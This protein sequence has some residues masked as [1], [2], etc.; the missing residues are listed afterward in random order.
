MSSSTENDIHKL[1]TYNAT[2]DRTFREV[3]EDLTKYKTFLLTED[4][5]FQ[6]SALFQD[7]MKIVDHGLM[8]AANNG[9]LHYGV[10]PKYV[11]MAFKYSI[12]KLKET[13]SDEW[14]KSN[15]A[16]VDTSSECKFLPLCGYLNSISYHVMKHPVARAPPPRSSRLHRTKGASRW[17]GGA[18]EGNMGFTIA[19]IRTNR[20]LK[21]VPRAPA[22]YG[23]AMM[24]LAKYNEGYRYTATRY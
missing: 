8:M 4:S 24:L 6:T 17:G 21:A 20:V 7:M 18:G 13:R 9:L 3:E 22:L 15:E 19:R 2:K 1:K 14:S 16:F 23:P 10:A 12:E 11:L 5:Q